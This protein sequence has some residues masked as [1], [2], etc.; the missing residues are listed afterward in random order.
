MPPVVSPAQIIPT[1]ANLTVMCSVPPLD[2]LRR[3]LL[4]RLE[5]CIV[6]N[7]EWLVWNSVNNAEWRL[8]GVEHLICVEW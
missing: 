1:H 4:T 3:N 8:T 5:L 7:G 6:S 2:G